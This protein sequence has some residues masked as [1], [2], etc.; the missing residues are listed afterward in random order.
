MVDRNKRRTKATD[1][2]AIEMYRL[3]TQEHLSLKEIGERFNCSAERA[4][5]IIKM[6][7]HT[8]GQ[9]YTGRTKQLES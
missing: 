5:Q 8:T 3:R 6:Y 2:R 9:P 7:C 1:Q 4:R